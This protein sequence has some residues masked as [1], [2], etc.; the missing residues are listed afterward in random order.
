[1][2]LRNCNSA[3]ALKSKQAHCVLRVLISS[4]TS[5]SAVCALA[6]IGG[7][8]G[9]IEIK[10]LQ[11]VARVGTPKIRLLLD[12]NSLRNDRQAQGFAH[13][14]DRIS[15]PRVLRGTGQVTDKRAG[16]RLNIAASCS[17]SAYLILMRPRVTPH[18]A[19][20]KTTAMSGNRICGSAIR[21]KR[22]CKVSFK[23]CAFTRSCPSAASIEWQRD[24]DRG[25]H[26]GLLDIAHRVRVCSDGLLY[27]R[28][29]GQSLRRKAPAVEQDTRPDCLDLREV[30]ARRLGSAIK[31]TQSV[32][33]WILCSL[34]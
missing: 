22:R 25:V 13:R 19:A 30:A 3:V 4:H 27:R 33:R 20:N 2:D 34:P 11:F 14:N 28:R 31:P 10:A 24:F 6:N 17:A 7:R 21:P 12:F 26:G 1:L 8:Q 9:P 15:E 16:S 23:R 29:I 32:W 5:G 18:V